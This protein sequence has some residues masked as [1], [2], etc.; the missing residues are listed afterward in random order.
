MVTIHLYCSLHSLKKRSLID[1]CEDETG[2]IERLWTFGGRPDAD[3][4]ER[5]TDGGEERGFLGESAGIGDYGGSIHLKAV[6]VMEAERLVPD[7]PVVELEAGLLQTFAAARMAAVK[8]RHVVFLRD[9]VDGVEQ[10]QE[11]LLRVDVLLAVCGQQDIPVFFKTE[12]PVDITRL[13]IL[14]IGVQH[15]GHR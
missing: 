1:T 12:T 6:V 2:V 9:G 8:D 7:D 13:Y 11:I 15:F 14:E 5:M 4:R 10:A 3:G